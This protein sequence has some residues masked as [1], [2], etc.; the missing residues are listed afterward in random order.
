M[1][2]TITRWF[3]YK[4]FTPGP[5]S[6]TASVKAAMMQD[7]GYSK[8][9]S[10]ITESVRSSI[11][12]ISKLPSD[13]YTT[14]LLP[15]SGTF[16]V[17][18]TIRTAVSTR[19]KLLIAANGAYGERMVLICKVLGIPHTILR[20][21]ERQ[22]VKT[23]DVLDNIDKEVTHVAMVHSETT[24]GILNPISEV[25]RAVKHTHPQL[26]FIGDCVSSFGAVDA[27]FSDLDFLVTCSNKL[28]QGVPGLALIIAKKEVLEKCKGNSRSAMLDLYRIYMNNGEF[29]C[30]PPFQSVVA[31]R[32]AI[33]EFEEE[34]GVAARQRRYQKNQ[35]LLKREME[36]LGFKL[37]INDEDQ[38]WIISTFLE[39]KSPN[40]SFSVLYKYLVDRNIVIY[41]GKLSKLPTFRIGTIGEL[42]EE[43][44]KMCVERIKEAF[45][46]MNIS[47]PLTD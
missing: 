1:L 29:L 23:Q 44:M 31:L 10:S 46:S 33:D 41:P 3:S 45:H 2:G 4:L 18:A 38:G 20:Y 13:A 26:V 16:G 32:K 39:P 5:L 27:D 19:H 37:Y 17:E 35:Q 15:G 40:Y 7:L 43:D 14:L 25:A 12:S 8:S 6:T 9:F 11:L 22:K 34:G 36:K 21:N 30:L 24:T 42:Y 28:L 47:L